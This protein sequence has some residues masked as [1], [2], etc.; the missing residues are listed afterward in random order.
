ME[1][2][3]HLVGKVDLLEIG[4]AVIAVTYIGVILKRKASVR[5]LYLVFA[6][7]RR[8]AKSRVR[9]PY[10]IRAGVRHRHHA[11]AGFSSRA[12]AR[13]HGSYT[14]RRTR[15]HQRLSLE[16]ASTNRNCLAG[17]HSAWIEILSW[18]RKKLNAAPP[19]HFFLPI[20][21]VFTQSL[22]LEPTRETLNTKPWM[23]D[24]LPEEL[25]KKSKNYTK[26]CRLWPVT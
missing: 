10:R 5:L 24:R 8:Y 12:G 9:I 13:D 22:Q 23:Q 26:C 1:K 2:P 11:I 25:T 15:R 4:G 17:I 7:T 19:A 6:R 16:R 3:T 20:G 18:R 21:F 14:L